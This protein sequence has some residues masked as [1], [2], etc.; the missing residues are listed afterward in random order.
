MLLLLIAVVPVVLLFVLIVEGLITGSGHAA[1][2]AS[3]VK[4]S[5]LP[6]E[7]DEYISEDDEIA[8]LRALVG[9][10][11][12]DVHTDMPATS[13]AGLPSGLDDVELQELVE[14]T[15]SDRRCDGLPPLAREEV[16][17]RVA[18]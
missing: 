14:M 9:T 5:D 11:R 12:R 1:S 6:A 16:L 17:R 15:N 2:P 18:G 8:Q 13:G 4:R 3:M 10:P 7:G